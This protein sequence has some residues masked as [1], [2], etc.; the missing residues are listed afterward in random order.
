MYSLKA[1]E[2]I[3]SKIFLVQYTLLFYVNRKIFSYTYVK[4]TK[5]VKIY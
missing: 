4:K 5:I 3:K 1:L 2:E